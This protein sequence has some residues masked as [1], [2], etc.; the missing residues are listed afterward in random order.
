MGRLKVLDNLIECRAVVFDKD[1]T[2]IDYH[3]VL[4][5]LFRSR[6]EAF[7]RFFGKESEKDFAKIC[8]YD[9]KTGSID[10]GGPL[11]TAS[12][13]E[14]EILCAGLI[15]E[16]GI[17]F[18]SARELAHQIFQE[19]E[20]SLDIETHLRPLPHAEELLRE[21]NFKGFLIAL[22][23][24]DGSIRAERMI[25]LLNWG[26]YFDLILGVDEVESPKPNPDFI[27][28]CSQRLGVPPLEMVVVG[29][30]CLDARMGKNARVGKTI[31]VL[32]GTG[33]LEQLQVCFDIVIPDLSLIKVE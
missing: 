26:N 27:F 29:D 20:D 19:A 2:L 33:S 30:S 14:E 10:P 16:K 22:A 23:T 12:R 8:G 7:T 21:L 5:S 1:G 4:E 18:P 24:G 9:L 32:T 6:L 11:N 31:G 3:L 25:S 15:F 17:P 28:K 13:R